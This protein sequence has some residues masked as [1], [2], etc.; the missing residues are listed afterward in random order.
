MLVGGLQQL[1]PAR[2]AGIGRRPNFTKTT[3][4]GDQADHPQRTG[5]DNRNARWHAEPI[6]FGLGQSH[7]VFGF[8]AANLS[9]LDVDGYQAGRGGACLLCDPLVRSTIITTDE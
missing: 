4:A 5:G 3:I 7:A 8:P 2:F 9:C 1:D 6:E